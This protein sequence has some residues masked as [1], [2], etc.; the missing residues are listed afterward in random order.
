M[1][2]RRCLRIVGSSY[3]ALD[4]GW[5]RSK[6]FVYSVSLQVKYW[7]SSLTMTTSAK[8]KQT[9]Y[10]PSTLGYMNRCTR[11]NNITSFCCHRGTASTR[12]ETCPSWRAQTALHGKWGHSV[13]LF[14]SYQK[15]SWTTGTNSRLRKISVAM[16]LESKNLSHGT[17]WLKVIRLPLGCRSEV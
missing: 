17:R 12:I 14:M 9:T 8:C 10:L 6:Q 2:L 4:D 5:T 16:V 15:H 1:N 3:T 13:E 11:C 7:I